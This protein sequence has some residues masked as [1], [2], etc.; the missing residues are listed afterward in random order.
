MSCLATDARNDNWI[1]VAPW[2]GMSRVEEGLRESGHFDIGCNCINY[3]C[4][5][6]QPNFRRAL[7]YATHNTKLRTSNLTFIVSICK[8]QSHSQNIY[9]FH[10][11]A[12]GLPC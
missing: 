12:P 6:P 4:L 7:S 9:C 10:G 1:L 8:F 3:V 2:D 11:T 5:A